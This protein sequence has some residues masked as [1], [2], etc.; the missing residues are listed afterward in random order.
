VGVFFVNAAGWLILMA[1]DPA[2][3]PSRKVWLG[4]LLGATALLGA[5]LATAASESTFAHFLDLAHHP[6]A[7]I[8]G[9]FNGPVAI[10]WAVVLATQTLLVAAVWVSVK[11]VLRRPA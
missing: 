4:C 3:R 9:L 2:W 8:P 6:A 7:I 1:K 10:K 5:H 11:S